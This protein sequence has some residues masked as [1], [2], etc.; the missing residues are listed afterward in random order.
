MPE[1]HVDSLPG[2]VTSL[3]DMFF[4]VGSIQMTIDNNNPEDRIPGTLWERVADGRFIVG[5]GGRNPSNDYRQYGYED[6]RGGQGSGEDSE[7][8]LTEDQLPRHTHVPDS[9]NSQFNNIVTWSGAEGVEGGGE[10]G[11]AINGPVPNT[12]ATEYLENIYGFP[13]F[14]PIAQKLSFVGLSPAQA[15]STSP[16]SYGVSIWKRTQ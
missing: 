10:T 12:Q 5:Q 3:V 4:P 16:I 9:N 8:S 6:N 14:Q 15:F 13:G 2:T 7:V 1:Q 11:G